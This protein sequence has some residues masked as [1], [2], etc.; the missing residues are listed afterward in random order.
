MSVIKR[1]NKVIADATKH[2]KA[3]PSNKSLNHIKQEEPESH[4]RS[5]Y[6]P[7]SSVEIFYENFENEISH[8]INQKRQ[9]SKLR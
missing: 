6:V 5:F 9:K 1:D 2:L 8:I 3:S 7:K 4:S